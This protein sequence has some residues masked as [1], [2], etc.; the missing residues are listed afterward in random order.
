MNFPI[1]KRQLI[2]KQVSGM[3][4]VVAMVAE[5][6]KKI[7][8]KLGPQTVK[9]MLANCNCDKRREMLNRLIPF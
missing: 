2:H 8:M 6:V 3:G 7:V 5:P 9:Q 1:K 4:D